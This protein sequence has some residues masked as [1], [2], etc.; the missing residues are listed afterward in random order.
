MKMSDSWLR[1]WV[2]P[3]L[4]AKALAS[5]LT[6]AGLEVDSLE[7]ASGQFSQVVVGQVKE[8][9]AH[10]DA[11][12]LTVCKVDVGES[13]PLQI[14]CGAQNVAA[15]MRVA[16]AL[17]GA[18]LPSGL[19]IKDAKLRGVASS[20]MLCSEEELGLADS[21]EG[22][23][24]LAP[25]APVGQDL[26]EYL[27]L[28]DTIIEID[29][30]PNRGDCLSIRGVAR[31]V[32]ALNDLDINHVDIQD[33]ESR[34]DKTLAVEVQDW[35]A[36]PR[37]C[38]R[39][40]SNVDTQAETPVWLVEKLRRAGVRSHSIVVDITN[41]VML[42]LGQPMHAFDAD[43]IE[44]GIVVRMSKDNESLV[45][46][47]GNKVQ[48]AKNNLLIADNTQV[49]AIAG[50]MGGLDSSVTGETKNIFLESAC[51]MPQAMA[52]VARHYGLSTDSSYRFERGVSPELTLLALARATALLVSLAG[53]EPG[54]VVEQVN[55]ALLP[56]SKK[57]ELRVEKLNRLLGV[58]LTQDEVRAYLQRLNMD[59]EVM[60]DSLDVTVPAYR[61][62]ISIEADL[63]EEVARIYGYNNISYAPMIAPLRA[64]KTT[65]TFL[66][67]ETI[68]QLMMTMGFFEAINYSFVCPKN[69]SNI[70]DVAEAIPLLNPISEELSHMRFGLLT[71]LISNVLYNT[72]RQCHDVKLFEI[73]LCFRK[74]G[75]ELTQRKMLSGVVSG[76]YGEDD[77]SKANRKYDFFDIKGFVE[78]LLTRTKGAFSF[79]PM[80][81]PNKA[82]HPGMSASVIKDGQVIGQVGVLHP[83]LKSLWGGSGSLLAFELELESIQQSVLPNYEPLSKYPMIRRDISFVVDEKTT[84]AEILNE[85]KQAQ[86]QEALLKDLTV[87]DVYQGDGIE[88]DKKSVALGL[89][90]QHPSRTLV[91][92][93]VNDFMAAIL[94]RLEVKFDIKLRE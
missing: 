24:A 21:S 84:I 52:G 94:K 64:Q 17:V 79:E 63:I 9:K 39:Y 18:K 71:G 48:L 56:K 91:D 12:K 38:G 70:Y 74:H 36:C 28:D 77:W 6:M 23:M 31:E 16:V 54:P 66:G 22:I 83:S 30:T 81:P 53:G 14:V 67:D 1:E 35:Q 82:Y 42:E 7:P 45:L 43:K 89:T 44:G 15:E 60:D 78:N 59:V 10:P 25:D 62:D 61:F 4:D 93:D 13:S 5:Q 33:V 19:K 26:R 57:V 2:N 69:Q 86:K 87:F 80:T 50:V 76:H 8:V 73:G 40:I 27:K 58:D 11:N 51:F 47:D 49:L 46:L 65:E 20:G 72:N 88:N 75:D 3:D 92:T 32:A 41:Y 90:L 29:L 37:Y 85:I 55:E 68:R 34:H